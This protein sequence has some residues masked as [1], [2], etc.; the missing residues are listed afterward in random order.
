MEGKRRGRKVDFEKKESYKLRNLKEKQSMSVSTLSKIR[1][2]VAT[3]A[4]A[5]PE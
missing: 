4:N 2:S 5:T 1:E 3:P